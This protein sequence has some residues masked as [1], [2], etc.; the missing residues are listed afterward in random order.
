MRRSASIEREVIPALGAK[1]LSALAKED[2][3]KM[4]DDIV[5]R[6]SPI[7]ANRVLAVFRRL[8]NWAV[9]RG[10]VAVSPCESIE[11]ALG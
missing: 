7:T 4:L 11:S 9:G 2:I 3:H 8:C 10:L 6:G 5:K 1:R